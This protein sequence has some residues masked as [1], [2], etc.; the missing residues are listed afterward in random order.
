MNISCLNERLSIAASSILSLWLFLS[1]LAAA[2]GN[3]VVLWLFYKNKSLRTISN[4]FLASLCVADFLVGLVIDPVWITIRFA[5]QPQRAHILKQVINLLW[6]HS[7]AATVFNLCCVSVD[8]FIAIRFPF[9]YQNIITKQ[10]C[11]AVIIMV[12][13]ISLFLPF[14]RTLVG[15]RTNVESLWFSLTLITLVLPITVVTL[16]YFSIFK[17]ARRQA[18]TIKSG[19]NH[20]NSNE[21]NAPACAMQ[22]YKAIKTIGI[23]LGVF[24]VSW[25]P[26]I[27]V[28]VVDYVTASDKCVDHKLAYVVWPW[29]EAIAFTSST[30]NPWIYCFRNGEFRNSLRLNCHRCSCLYSR[31]PVDL[32][33]KS[34]TSKISCARVHA[35]QELYARQSSDTLMY[36]VSIG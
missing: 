24:I 14:S 36:L 35:S 13:L 12:W 6:I 22:N 9:R 3:A 30:I 32:S 16:C 26:S 28:S 7:T 29:I 5:T 1:G 34:D 23:V 8:R 21:K 31:D 10:R 2:I 4:R 15:N 27:V 18:S 20:Q 19:G 17:A 33:L 25:M 11:Y